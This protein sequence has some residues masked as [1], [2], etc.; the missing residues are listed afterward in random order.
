MNQVPRVSIEVRSSGD[1]IH[2]VLTFDEPIYPVKTTKWTRFNLKENGML[3]SVPSDS[4]V[5]LSDIS[6]NTTTTT[7]PSPF[8]SKLIKLDSKQG[9]ISFT[10]KFDENTI[11]SGPMKLYL[12]VSSSNLTDMNLFAY[13]RKY[14]CNLDEVY[15]EGAFGYGLDCVTKGWQ[16]VA[17]RKIVKLEEEKNNDGDESWCSDNKPFDTIDH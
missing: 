14:D 3:S 13:I 17:L 11:V 8:K 4:Y 2:K 7:I 15:F 9:H 16:R 5:S 1:Y 6:L 12:N 10:Y